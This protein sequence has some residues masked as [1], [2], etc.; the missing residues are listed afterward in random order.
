MVRVGAIREERKGLR[1]EERVVK[2]IVERGYGSA[3][4]NTA[5][6]YQRRITPV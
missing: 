6:K 2:R 4:I 5:R 1:A 3:D